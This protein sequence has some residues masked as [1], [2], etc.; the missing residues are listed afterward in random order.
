MRAGRLRGA[1]GEAFTDIVN[2][3]IGG[4]DLGPAMAARALAPFGSHAINLAAIT[5][6]IVTGPDCHPDPQKRW[7]M[8]WPYLVFYGAI[9]LMA[10]GLVEI[11]GALPKDLITAI[12]GLALFA[13]L[14]G[15][16]GAMMARGGV[17]GM[18]AICHTINPRLHPDDIT[19]IINHAEDRML[20]LDLTFVPL[21]ERIAAR[22]TTIE[23]FVILTD[24]AHMPATSLKNATAY[25]EYIAASDPDFIWAKRDYTGASLAAIEKVAA[26]KGY[27]LVGCN[28]MGIRFTEHGRFS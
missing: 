8:A 13:P 28:I 2:I 11:L 5:A 12:A 19:Y 26:R 14:M 16:M 20:F 7:L 24:A 1:T 10:A 21:V 18:Q 3:G 17:P 22:L 23:R 15:A 4:S 9:G 6:S 25:E 27:S